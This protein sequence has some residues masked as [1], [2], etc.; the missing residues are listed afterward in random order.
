MFEDLEESSGFNPETASRQQD[1]NG[2]KDYG[3][4][5]QG[6]SGNQGNSYGGGGGGGGN[7]GGYQKRDSG[8]GYQNRSGGG[9]GGFVRKEEVL[10]DPYV[11]IAMH[12]EKDFPEEAKTSLY[13]IASKLIAKK[14]T[15]RIN[16]DDPEFIKRLTDLSNKFVEVYVPW[17]NFNELQSKHSWNTITCKHIAQQHFMGWEKIPDP[18]KAILS[19]QV[20]L[21]FGDRNNSV[22]MALITYTKDG[23]SRVTE[24]TKET[25]RP[26]FV[27][28]VASSY[29]FPVINIARQ[30]SGTILEKSFGI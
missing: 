12:V 30:S 29:G 27:I 7:S 8:G 24:L 20:R 16:A 18:V 4:K 23:A 14:V 28:K 6:S 11:P 15:V 13:N 22:A 9:G 21:I 26:S 10:E 2:Y 1:N 3:R 17:R 19:S 5:D 25:G